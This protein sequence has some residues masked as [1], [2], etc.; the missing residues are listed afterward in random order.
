[1]LKSSITLTG[2]LLIQKFEA[3]GTLVYST[4]VPNLVVTSGKEFLASRMVGTAYDPMEY[5]AIG[6]DSTIGSVAQTTLVNELGRVAVTS[7]SPVGVNT[8]FTAVFPAGTATG[9][10]VEAGIFNK[11]ATSVLT[12]DGAAAVASNT[13]TYINHGL[14]TG[15]KVTYTNGGGTSIGG[16]T[17]GNT[18]YVVKLTNDTFKLAASYADATAGSPVIITLSDGV[19]ANHKITY[20]TMLARTT[21]P[22]IT[23]SVSQTISISWVISVG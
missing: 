22:V 4:E 5:M 19:G 18:Y 21:F 2:R 1:M 14:L 15:Y 11:G 7:A 16:L 20:G 12:F 8:T 10:I 3:D 9:S 6:D 23:K 17:S 13:I